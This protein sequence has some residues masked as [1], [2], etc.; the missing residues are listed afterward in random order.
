M[1]RTLRSPGLQ[2]GCEHLTFGGV[3][4]AQLRGRRDSGGVGVGDEVLAGGAPRQVVAA[5]WQRSLAARV[6]PEH[7]A[8]SLVYEHAELAQVRAGHP[9]TG[10]LPLLRDTLVTIAD[11]AM[12][13]MLVTDAQ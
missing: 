1:R 4:F 2:P 11:E 3:K 8:P 9:L 10:V 7:G 12:H 13:M 5:S 6:D